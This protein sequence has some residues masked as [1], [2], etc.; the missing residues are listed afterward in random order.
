[1]LITSKTFQLTIVKIPIVIN[2]TAKT[3]NPPINIVLKSKYAI[4]R[5]EAAAPIT[6]ATAFR[7]VPSL[8]FISSSPL[9]SSLISW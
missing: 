3:S 4:R 8:S 6:L 5:G 1:M 2:S 9:D 7:Q